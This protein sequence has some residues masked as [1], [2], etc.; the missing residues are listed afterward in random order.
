[1]VVVLMSKV[2]DVTEVTAMMT[3]VMTSMITSMVTVVTVV[4]MM[5]SMR[6]YGWRGGPL[7]LLRLVFK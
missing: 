2:T 4:T 5:A 3:A 1:M 6:R 7:M